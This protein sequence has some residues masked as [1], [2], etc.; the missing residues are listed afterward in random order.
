MEEK[1]HQ[2]FSYETYS[3]NSAVSKDSAQNSQRISGYSFGVDKNFL[4]LGVIYSSGEGG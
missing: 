2:N 3:L 1:C 4:K